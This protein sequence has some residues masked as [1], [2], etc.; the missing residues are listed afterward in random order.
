MKLGWRGALGIAISVT[1]LVILFRSISWSEVAENLRSANYLLLA[2]SAIVATCIFPL[3]A[4]R[5]RTILDPVAPRLPFGKLWRATAIGMMVNNVL[6]ARAGEPARAFALWREAPEVPFSTAFASLAVD[7]VFDA[8]VVLILMSAA[9]L[10]PAFPKNATIYDKP[11]ADYAVPFLGVTLIAL[12]G[13]YALVFFPG[14]LIRGFELIVR[15]VA[16]RIEDRGRD[17]LRSFSNGLSVLR[18]PAHFLA[19]FGWT[20]LHWLVNALAFWIAFRAV[21][22]KPDQSPFSAALFLQGLI[23]VGVAA[24]S[25]PGFFGIFEALAVVGLGLYGVDKGPAATWGIA[26]HVVSFIP[27]TI[28]GVIYF[29]RL[30]LTF[31]ELGSAGR[32]NA[33]AEAT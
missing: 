20:L 21:H 14:I 11:V 19:I 3:R 24:P 1:L 25:S 18:S 26:F 29:A 22:L 7:R 13:L 2:L 17:A 10:D 33:G 32:A 30:G 16:P 28:I 12:G 31:G 8:I 6:P 5:W 4:R 9:M 23:A 27:I 15:R